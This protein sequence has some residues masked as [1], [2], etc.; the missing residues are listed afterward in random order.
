ML[1][2]LR[3]MDPEVYEAVRNEVRRQRCRSSS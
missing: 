3:R 1:N 2:E